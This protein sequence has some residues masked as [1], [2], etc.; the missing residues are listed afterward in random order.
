MGSSKTHR[1]FVT[2]YGIVS[3][4]GNSWQECR[5]G[6]QKKENKVIY[7]PEYTK[8]NELKSYL[9][10]PILNYEPMQE[11]TRKDKRSMGRVSLMSVHAAK[12]TMQSAGLILNDGSLSDLVTNGSRG[13]AAGSST[14]STDAI[15]SMAKL[16][17]TESSDCNANTYIK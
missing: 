3:A 6:F 7:M 16:F 14:G 10:S 15:V 2:G 1:V 8:V 17:I 5:A 4:F 9:A 11:L 12:L 13:V